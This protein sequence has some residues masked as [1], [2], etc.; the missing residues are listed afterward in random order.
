MNGILNGIAHVSFA[1]AGFFVPAGTS[2]ERRGLIEQVAGYSRTE[3]LVQVLTGGKRWIV[4]RTAS[5][6]S[7][8]CTTCDI[9]IKTALCR[10]AGEDAAHCLHCAFADRP[11]STERPPHLAGLPQMLPAHSDHYPARRSGLQAA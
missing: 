1:G 8:V 11:V 4:Q 5:A 2:V 9:T 3:D 7:T 10:V 6:S